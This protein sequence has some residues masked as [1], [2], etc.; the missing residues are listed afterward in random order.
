[1]RFST[2]ILSFVLIAHLLVATSGPPLMYT[3]CG[4]RLVDVSVSLLATN[5]V[6]HDGCSAEQPQCEDYQCCSQSQESCHI[7]IHTTKFHPEYLAPQSSPIFSQYVV[8]LFQQKIAFFILFP[9]TPL[10]SI[11]S[12]SPADSPHRQYADLP[13]LFRS[14]LI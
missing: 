3:F 10:Q 13:I 8:S 5:I 2:Q 7:E 4:E 12:I 6:E 9:Q 11:P 1:M 14:L